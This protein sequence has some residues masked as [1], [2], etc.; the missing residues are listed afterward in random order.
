MSSPA[1]LIATH[2]SALPHPDGTPRQLPGFTSQLL[3][4]GLRSQVQQAATDIGDAIIHLLES[5]G[6]RITTE[7]S[8]PTQTSDTKP[9]A[10]VHCHHCDARV[11]QL[12]IANPARVMTGHHFA[13]T[14][15]PNK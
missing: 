11:L 13:L 3:P 4:E 2:L 6:Y 5:N 15:C 8:Q 14:E 1:Q 7:P 9:V 10:S 12:N